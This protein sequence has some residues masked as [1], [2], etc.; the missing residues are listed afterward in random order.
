L[1]TV[2]LEDGMQITILMVSL[3][4]RKISGFTC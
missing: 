3:R 1:A 4:Y 2:L